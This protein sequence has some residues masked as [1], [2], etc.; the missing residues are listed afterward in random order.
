MRYYQCPLPILEEGKVYPGRII[1]T[2]EHR[3]IFLFS[4]E[5]AKQILE[6]RI[7]HHRDIDRPKFPRYYR[8]LK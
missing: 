5:S 3:L 8:Y 6:D 2:K 1:V 4:R 7:I